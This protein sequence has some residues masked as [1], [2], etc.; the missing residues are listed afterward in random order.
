MRNKMCMY[1]TICAIVSYTKHSYLPLFCSAAC[2]FA[3]MLSM[4][5]VKYILV[6]TSMYWMLW[7]TYA[8]EA[9]TTC[10]VGNVSRKRINNCMVGHGHMTNTHH[11]I[12]VR[13]YCGSSHLALASNSLT[14]IL[15]VIPRRHG[16]RMVYLHQKWLLQ[17]DRL[18]AQGVG[19]CSLLRP[20]YR[21]IWLDVIPPSYSPRIAS[22]HVAG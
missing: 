19:G 1:S 3:L 9:C 13:S 10:A 5:C 7:H 15:R 17:D 16:H 4:E 21:W 11:R 22:S 6:Y 2:Y 18:G 20:R 12:N 8:C 14:L